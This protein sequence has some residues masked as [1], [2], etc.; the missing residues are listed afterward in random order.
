ME[1]KIKRLVQKL[2]KTN[3]YGFS[4]Q[5]PD[6]VPDPEL[7]EHFK[8]NYNIRTDVHRT[9]V[10]CQIR[11]LTKYEE[12]SDNKFKVRCS[13]IPRGLPGSSKAKLIQLATASD[14][15]IDRAKKLLLST[16]DPVAWAELM[17]GFDDNDKKWNIRSYQKEQLRCSSLRVAAREGRRSGK[18]FAMALK[19]LYYAFNLKVNRGR[20]AEGKEVIKGPDIMIV[21][22]YQAQLTNIFEEIEKLIKR[23]YEL[24]NQVTTGTND[25]LYIKTPTFKL[26]LRNGAVI[27]GFVSGLGVKEDGSGGGTIRGQS[28]NIIYL[29]E[30]DMI[31]ED[32]LD[33]VINP[34]LATTPETILIA[35]STPIGK[36]AKF[37]HWCLSR[38]DFKEDYY[39]STVLPHWE[40][41]KDEIEGEST[42]ESF[43]AEYMADFIEGSYGVFRPSWIQSARADYEYMGS[44]D[45]TEIRTKLKIPDPANILVAIGV[46]W[47]KNAGT[48]FYVTGYSASI[49]CWFGLE[50]VNVGA[51]EHSG[52]RWMKELIRLNYK[53]SP[54]WIYADEGYGHTIIEDLKLQAYKLRGKPNKTPM[55][56]AT[57]RL[58]DIL[59]AFNFSRNVLLKDP[60][61]GE[62]IKKA[63]KHFLVENAVRTMEDGLFK[64]PASD[65]ILKKQFMNYIVKRRHPTTNKPVFGVENERIGD[66]RLDAMMLSLAA[67]SLE[68]SIYSGRHLPVSKPYYT[69]HQ[70]GQESKSANDYVSPH[71]E[72]KELMSALQKHRVPRAANVLKIMRGGS[73]EED[74][75]TKEKYKKQGIWTTGNQG[76]KRSKLKKDIDNT[77]KS[78]ILEGLQRNIGT[79]K[80]GEVI[81]AP[82][83]ANRRPRSGRGRNWRDK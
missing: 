9:C 64:F 41:I 70:M 22:P 73:E 66:H 79:S 74:R 69:D 33:K 75:A 58:S 59:I 21:T 10:N 38:P 71:D 48:E 65:E 63:G 8:E 47:N 2:Y 15:P 13:Y 51:S 68:E 39:P 77:S 30:M 24:R 31:P 19:L 62:D 17:F 42:K 76:S 20:D 37:Y 4:H 80:S 16:I 43:D 40:Q 49:G 29:D 35:T 14:I 53:W 34:I 25:N 54:N 67:L 27:Q 82:T 26:E 3:E 45:N 23:N 55:D 72:A 81:S 11:Q 5:D 83:G 57:V 32:I 7:V 6:A 61:T 12:T 18:T 46:D 52:Q 60:I 36:R 44:K 1:P 56:E 78:S 50:A 28:A